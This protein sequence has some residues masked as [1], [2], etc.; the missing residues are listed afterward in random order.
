MLPRA[1]RAEPHGVEEAALRA[2]L[3]G[4]ARARPADHRWKAFSLRGVEDATTSGT[5]LREALPL[6]LVGKEARG[7]KGKGACAGGGQVVKMRTNGNN[8]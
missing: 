4:A 5:R 2:D 1:R 3:P 8:T 6:D 7:G